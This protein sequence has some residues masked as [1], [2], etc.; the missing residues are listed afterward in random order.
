[1]SRRTKIDTILDMDFSFL[2]SLPVEDWFTALQQMCERGLKTWYDIALVID[3]AD[4]PTLLEDMRQKALAKSQSGGFPVA[5]PS[6]PE[7]FKTWAWESMVPDYIRHERRRLSSYRVAFR[8]LREYAKE[9][10]DARFDPDLDGAFTKL[11][12]LPKAMQ[13]HTNQ[14]EVF[15]AINRLD[16]RSFIAYANGGSLPPAQPNPL[17]EYLDALNQRYR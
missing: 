10:D 16:T 9:L 3:A 14:A 1:M 8:N 4:N 11:L 17:K 5:V 15:D 7:L 6:D 13:N 12:H 2:D